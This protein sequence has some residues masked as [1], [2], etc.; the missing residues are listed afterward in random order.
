MK[1][2]IVL[3]LLVLG[4]KGAK[5]ES[6]REAPK[7]DT[8][9]P[10]PTG[11]RPIADALVGRNPRKLAFETAPLI[12]LTYEELKAIYGKVISKETNLGGR[13]LFPQAIDI[14]GAPPKAQ[15]LEVHFM[16]LDGKVATFD[17]FLHGSVQDALVAALETVRGQPSGSLAS[18]ELLW[19]TTP[20]LRLRLESRGGTITPYLKLTVSPL[21]GQ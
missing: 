7:E 16:I 1:G 17:I 20:A 10:A 2:A 5:Q 4:C 13:L 15:D 21:P 8:T 9:L 14:P 11:P 6:G 19:N 12:G 18:G 3:A